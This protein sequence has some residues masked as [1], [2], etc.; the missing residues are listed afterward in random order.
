MIKISPSLVKELRNKTGAGMMDCKKALVESAG[1]I[2]N[3]IN[4]LRKKGQKVAAKRTERQ[5]L[6]GAVLSQ[7][8]PDNTFGVLLCLGCETDFVAKNEDFVKLAES[9]L[10]VALEKKVNSKEQLLKEQLNETSIAEKIT[11]QIGI[12][13]EKISIA[14]YQFLE[15][16]FV[17]SYIHPGNRLAS[18]V[19]LSEKNDSIDE[20]GKFI[21]MQVASMKPTV[22]APDEIEQNI[23][24]KE[25]EIAR[26]QLKDTLK[27]KDEKMVE[28]I[29]KGRI[30]KFSKEI[31]LNEQAF[32]MNDKQSVKQYLKEKSST[33]NVKK[34]H[35]YQTG[36]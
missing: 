8:S 28:N 6:E 27:G 12:I 21:A 34:F 16:D 14:D 33:L 26:E 13:G 7:T 23:I 30:S 5:T 22:V 11:E 19:S 2:E 1:N 18:I 32:I 9:I 29:L 17:K 3:A 25:L 10:K 31:S 4:I 20:V 15:G 35:W 36:A 24:D